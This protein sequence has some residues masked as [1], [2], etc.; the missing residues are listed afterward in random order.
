MPKN[1]NTLTY[2]TGNNSTEYIAVSIPMDAIDV[3]T[4]DDTMMMHM[5]WSLPATGGQMHSRTIPDYDWKCINQSRYMREKE[6]LQ[7]VEKQNIL[8]RNYLV[9]EPEFSF[10]T[11]QESWESLLKSIG[12]DKGNYAILKLRK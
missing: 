5:V 1:N 6:M 9:P 4:H 2:F 11:A 10:T 12:C 3:H 7:I 8:Y